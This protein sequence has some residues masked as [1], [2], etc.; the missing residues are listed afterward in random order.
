MGSALGRLKSSSQ[1]PPSGPS[2]QRLVDDAVPAQEQTQK[3]QDLA[4]SD[5]RDNPDRFGFSLSYPF[6]L[7]PKP[8]RFIRWSI[9]WALFIG[10]TLTATLLMAHQY[11]STIARS[12]RSSILE[13]N[14]QP[15]YQLIFQP[16]KFDQSAGALHVLYTLT[17]TEQV[18]IVLRATNDTTIET[19]SASKT[20]KAG[21]QL[22][23]FQ[24]VYS[25]VTDTSNYPFDVYSTNITVM[26]TNTKTK[27]L[28][29]FNLLFFMD[30]PLQSF[31]YD[32]LIYFPFEDDKGK[33]LDVVKFQLTFR[34]SK[35][36][37]VIVLFTWLLMHMWTVMIVFLAA[38]C[39]FRDRP[40]HP[41]M[42][43]AAASIFSMSTIR[44]IQP[45]API[46][47]T[48]Y[49]MGTY[50]WSV[51]VSCIAAFGLFVASFRK[52]KPESEKDKLLKKKEKE[53]KLRKFAREEAEEEEKRRRK[54]E[55]AARS[56]GGKVGDM[57]NINYLS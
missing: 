45:S 8:Y 13:S 47:G 30:Q 9:L 33:P 15:T 35:L 25:I 24:V 56:V 31:D 11:V 36:T 57:H 34:R 2:F 6:F 12:N 10:I 27:D 28:A 22:V 42:V 19:G 50:V 44:S 7:T 55:E 29:S 54:E 16:L 41:F 39:F 51:T 38:Q 40:A 32:D 37:K 43:W 48:K 14:Q 17:L 4:S 3:D 26:V 46:I 20:F 18:D 52:Y 49:D 5:D 53:W 21:D 1:T 23:P